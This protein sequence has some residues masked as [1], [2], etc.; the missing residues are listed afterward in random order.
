MR[1]LIFMLWFLPAIISPAQLVHPQH[2]QHDL[3]CMAK[4]IYHEARGE[5]P[6]GQWLVAQVVLVR[7]QD[8]RWPNTVCGV[9]L[10]AKQFSWTHQRVVV[11]DPQAW[12]RSWLLAHQVLQHHTAQHTE[13]NHFVHC[14]KTRWKK[15][16]GTKIGKHCFF[17]T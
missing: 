16:W 3:W 17:S 10:Q 11:N 1:A 9:V 5:A 14:T 6:L 15:N 4:N 7:T 12:H 13:Y 8:S 2:T